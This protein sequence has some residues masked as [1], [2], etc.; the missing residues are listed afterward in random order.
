MWGAA[1]DDLTPLHHLRMGSLATLLEREFGFEEYVD[2]ALNMPMMLVRRCACW[3]GQLHRHP[4]C[5]KAGGIA[6]EW[7][8]LTKRAAFRV[9]L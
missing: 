9:L 1:A 2:L 8:T 3:I 6:K 4:M 7:V 5:C